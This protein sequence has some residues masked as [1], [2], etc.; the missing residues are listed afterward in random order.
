MMGKTAQPISSLTSPTVSNYRGRL[1]RVVCGTSRSCFCSSDMFLLRGASCIVKSGRHPG[2]HPWATLKYT[3]SGYVEAVGAISGTRQ[4][5]ILTWD[6]LHSR[7]H[8]S[9]EYKHQTSMNGRKK[10]NIVESC[11]NF[12]SDATLSRRYPKSCGSVAL[13]DGSFPAV[14]EWH[15]ATTE[16][17]GSPSTRPFH[18]QRCGWDDAHTRP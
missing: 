15:A 5:Y 6:A 17:T 10:R 9:P 14:G 16:G 18:M 7:F 11:R 13:L 12:V 1:S 4:F 8:Q 2:G 3:S